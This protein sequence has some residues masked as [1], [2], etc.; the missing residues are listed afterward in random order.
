MVRLLSVASFGW[1]VGF[2]YH[3]ILMGNST[4]WDF[5]PARWAQITLAAL[6]PLA[7]CGVLWSL[8]PG[9]RQ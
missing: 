6:A 5:S 8:Y 4:P 2:L 7:I 9:D 1:A 3:Q